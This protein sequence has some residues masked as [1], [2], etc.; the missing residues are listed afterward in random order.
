MLALLMPS[1][2]VIVAPFTRVKSFDDDTTPD[3][4]ELLLQSVNSLG[5]PG[6]LVGHVHVDLFEHVPASGNAKGRRVDYWDIEL[7]TKEEQRTHW[8][9]ATQMY[10]FRLQVNPNVVPA[11]DRFVL[12]VTYTTP[13]G[14]HLRDE[15]IIDGRAARR[16]WRG[17]QR[18][19]LEG[20]AAE[21]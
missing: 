18:P 9:Q 3:G 15:C 20:R 1:K 19:G 10:E 12:Q 5:D 11:K 14:D 7:S 8:N 16:A 21:Q 6:M 17:A 13:M 2:I 4:I